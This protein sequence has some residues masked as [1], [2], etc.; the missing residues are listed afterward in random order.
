MTLWRLGVVAASKSAAIGKAAY[1]TRGLQDTTEKFTFATDTRA[2]ISSTTYAAPGNSRQAFSSATNGYHAGGGSPAVSN[3]NKFSFSTETFSSAATMPSGRF[4]AA[5]TAS[6]TDAYI[7]GGVGPAPAT[8]RLSSTVKYTF[9]SDSWSNIPATLSQTLFR[10]N[11]AVSTGGFANRGYIFGGVTESD[12]TRVSAVQKM[13]FAT[14]AIN[15]LGTGL[16]SDRSDM[17]AGCSSTHGYSFGGRGGANPGSAISTVE[18]F[19][20]SDDA[21][22]TVS[23]GLS[24]SRVGLQQG[25]GGD[26]SQGYAISGST[27]VSPQSPVTTVDKYVWS[28]DTRSTLG[29]GVT[30]GAYYFSVFSAQ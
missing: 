24:S 25:N 3:V 16:S 7:S 12:P 19:G 22:S 13:T 23:T 8:P 21:R 18:K 30:T 26:T 1:V 5:S 9:S 2:S 27:A 15:S 14:E 6:S 29:T 28:S 17:A 20:Y 11:A 4:A 10:L